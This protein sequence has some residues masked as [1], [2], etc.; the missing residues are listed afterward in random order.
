MLSINYYVCVDD[1]DGIINITLMRME[2]AASAATSHRRCG[3][4]VLA[5]T[6]WREAGEETGGERGGRALAKI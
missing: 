4:M 2:A 1:I 3:G 6:R 5:A